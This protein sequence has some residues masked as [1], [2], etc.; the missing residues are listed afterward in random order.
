LPHH[1]HRNEE[2]ALL[3]VESNSFGFIKEM[4][5]VRS[6]PVQNTSKPIPLSVASKGFLPKAHSNRCVRL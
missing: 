1:P 4:R 2:A 3:P 5:P 6:A